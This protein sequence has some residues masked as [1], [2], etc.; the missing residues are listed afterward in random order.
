MSTRLEH[1]FQF[2]LSDLS[3]YLGVPIL[4]R[5]NDYLEDV[6]DSLRFPGHQHPRHKLCETRRYVSDYICE[7]D[8]LQELDPLKRVADIV[9]QARVG[10]R[11]LIE[12]ASELHSA[13][14]RLVSN[15]DKRDNPFGT[16][17]QLI[18]TMHVATGEAFQTPD[19]PTHTP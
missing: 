15:V 6:Q 12:G 19:K 13:N 2:Y 17:F 3:S 18:I 10:A 14:W 16:L 8:V 1:S 7:T 5:S 9:A 11:K 4:L